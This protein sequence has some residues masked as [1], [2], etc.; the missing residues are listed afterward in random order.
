MIF[1]G[2][3]SQSL[4]PLGCPPNSENMLSI[5]NSNMLMTLFSVAFF[6]VHDII[7]WHVLHVCNMTD[8][9]LMHNEWQCIMQYNYVLINITND[10]VVKKY[11]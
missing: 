9:V 4:F 8:D 10:D 6:V 1:A 3:L 5:G 7:A 11:D 2:D